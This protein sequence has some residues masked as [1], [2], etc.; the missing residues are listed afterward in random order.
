M[1]TKDGNNKVFHKNIHLRFF[2]EIAL[3]M[4]IMVTILLDNKNVT[5]RFYLLTNAM[6]H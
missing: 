1:H 6:I 4:D 3:N 5:I 2:I